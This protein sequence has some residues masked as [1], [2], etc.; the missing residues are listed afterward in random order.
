MRTSTRAS[1]CL[2]GLAE[3]HLA[4]EPSTGAVIQDFDAPVV[5]TESNPVKVLADQIFQE[6]APSHVIRY[7]TVVV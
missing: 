7:D 1:S 5:S 6:F 4:K 3:P 2:P